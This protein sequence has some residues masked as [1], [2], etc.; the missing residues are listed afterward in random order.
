MANQSLKWPAPVILLSLLEDVYVFTD[1][2]TPI[3]KEDG[4]G[5]AWRCHVIVPWA[6]RIALLSRLPSAEEYK[7][8]NSPEAR[9]QRPQEIGRAAG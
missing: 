8:T 3:T 2:P 7:T 1:S 5:G 9:L 4:G 6:K